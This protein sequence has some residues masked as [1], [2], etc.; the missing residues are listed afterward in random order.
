MGTL[1]PIT[2]YWDIITLTKS[3]VAPLDKAYN[4]M[5]KGHYVCKWLT[6]VMYYYVVVKI[7]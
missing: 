4:V 3:L 6:W 1:L 2:Y 7:F 5:V